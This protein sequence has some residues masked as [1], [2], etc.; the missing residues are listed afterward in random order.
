MYLYNE[1]EAKVN[2]FYTLF[3]NANINKT[4][5]ETVLLLEAESTIESSIWATQ[6]VTMYWTATETHWY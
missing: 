3:W 2:L 1:S 4:I 6:I 5:K